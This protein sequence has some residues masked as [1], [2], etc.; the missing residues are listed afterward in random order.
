M[1]LTISIIAK[2]IDPLSKEGQQGHGLNAM[3]L[4]YMF[5]NCD[6]KSIIYFLN[7]VI[8]VVVVLL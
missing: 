4:K 1:I 2:F 8:S 3:I 6:F 7:V 5:K